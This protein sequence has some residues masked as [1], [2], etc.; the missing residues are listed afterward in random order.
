MERSL[1]TFAL[2]LFILQLAAEVF[3]LTHENENER[4][5]Q[6]RIS[7]EYIKELDKIL[8]IL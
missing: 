5:N 8:Y 6:V 4:D 3:I 1:T 7:V 2:F